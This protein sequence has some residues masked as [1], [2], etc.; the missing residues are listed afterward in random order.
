MADKKQ[1][2]RCKSPL[3]ISFAGGDP[4]VPSYYDE[5]GGGAQHHH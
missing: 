5:Q 1:L 3:R 4:D 2:I